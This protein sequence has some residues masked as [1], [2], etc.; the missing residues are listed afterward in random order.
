MRIHRGTL[1]LGLQLVVVLAACSG[2]PEGQT[3]AAAVSE[4][5]AEIAGAWIVE[6]ILGG[7]IIDNSRVTLEFVGDRLAG[8]ASCNAYT[9]P[10]SLADGR[11]SIGDAAVTMMACPE[12]LMNQEQRFLDALASADGF[13]L[14]DT[15]ALFLTSS[16]KDVVRAR[17]E[18]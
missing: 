8:R 10:W 5:K 17:R 2:G 11:L 1:A 3:E 18:R 6:D 15:G 13:R 16:G 4:P 7:G 9:A 14:D 12:A